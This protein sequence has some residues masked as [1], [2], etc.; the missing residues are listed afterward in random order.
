[1]GLFPPYADKATLEYYQ[2]LAPTFSASGK[3]VTNR[4]LHSFLER[5]EPGAKILDL[6]CG[7]GLDSLEMIQLGFD[8]VPCDGS[9]SVAKKA[10]ELLGRPVSVQ[11]FDEL[12]AEGA[13]DAVWASASLLHV[14]RA[15][16]PAIL[17]KVHRALRSNGLHFASYKAGGTEGRDTT[18][19][20][21]NYLSREQLEHD[22]EQSAPWKML[23]LEEYTGGGYVEGN[24]QGPWIAV[25]M[26]KIEGI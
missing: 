11:R 18:G 13:Y 24:G 6:G 26:Q 10:E 8:P 22:Y 7:G 9:A 19:R 20:Y 4:Y 21:F 3:H 14:P 2:H 25:I 17:K 1:M 16:L 23:W 15:Y 12:D 5:L